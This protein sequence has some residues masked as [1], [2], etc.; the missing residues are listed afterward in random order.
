MPTLTG[1]FQGKP[2]SNCRTPRKPA[3]QLNNVGRTGK[4]PGQAHRIPGGAEEIQS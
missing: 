2:S 4:G 3:V 1:G